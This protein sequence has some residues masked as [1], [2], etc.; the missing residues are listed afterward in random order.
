MEEQKGTEK[1][2]KKGGKNVMSVLGGMFLVKEK[3]SKQ[4]P[5]MVYVT[6]LLMAIITNTYIAEEKNR[7]LTQTSKRLND[8]QVEYIQLKSAIMDAS[9]QSILAKRLVGTGM[10]EATEPLK[11]INVNKEPNHTEEP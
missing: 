7:E 4:F 8:L 9:K 3:F 6:L 1:K 5:F 10:K 11:R 2:K